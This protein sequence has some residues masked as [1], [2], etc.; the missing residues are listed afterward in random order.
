MAAALFAVVLAFTPLFVS[1]DIIIEDGKQF[2]YESEFFKSIIMLTFN[3]ASPI[4]ADGTD[5]VYTVSLIHG[6]EAFGFN[7]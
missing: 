4:L 5:C 1:C 7:S 3:Y 6:K 2:N